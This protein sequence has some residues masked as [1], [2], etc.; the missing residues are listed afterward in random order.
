VTDAATEA[1][2][3][4][5][6]TGLRVGLDIG[7]TKVEGVVIAD[8]DDR[9]LHRVRL[10]T[11]FGD[12]AVVDSAAQAVL[13]LA[14]LAGGLDRLAGVGI[15]IPGA[16]DSAAGRVMHAVNLGVEDLALG[17]E[18]AARVGL[19]VHVE[20]DVNAAALGA[21]AVLE[22]DPAA[23]L[24]AGDSMAYLNLGT[25][26]AAGIVLEGR[27]WRGSR[28]VAGEIGHIPVVPD[29]ERCNCGQRGCLETMAS[30]GAIAR[31]WRADDPTAA[32]LLAAADRGDAEAI[33]VRDQLFAY[34][35]AAIRVLVLTVDVDRVVLGGGVSS[36]GEPLLAGVRAALRDTAAIAPFLAMQQLDTR[37][38]LLP[39]GV[40]VAAVGAA[41]GAVPAAR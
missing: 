36:L 38:D 18:L 17:P 27:L 33:A 3:A 10:A 29:G 31:H 1:I 26:M 23:A 4:A 16:V 39:Q 37:V 32:A 24:R 9:V 19:P 22:A 13:D 2:G 7:G 30:G 8:G 6:R 28:G 5:V 34:T 35:A 41:L 15:G 25:G 12:D 21:Y 20:N 40:P 14:E 11:G